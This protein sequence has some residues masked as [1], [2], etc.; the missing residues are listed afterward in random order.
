MR[1]LR[2]QWVRAPGQAGRGEVEAGA[3]LDV[4]GTADRVGR[5][6]VEQVP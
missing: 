3:A 4:R 5:A 6:Q 2:Q 1:P